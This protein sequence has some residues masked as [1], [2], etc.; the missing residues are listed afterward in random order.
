MKINL[1]KRLKNKT[2]WITVTS[3]VVMVIGLIVSGGHDIGLWSFTWTNTINNWIISVVT[4]ILIIL[5]S[6]G[7]LIDP[8]SPGISD[9]S[10]E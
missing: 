1:K 9:S 2:W 8:T 3:E 4:G 6:L 10:G 7:I 5:T